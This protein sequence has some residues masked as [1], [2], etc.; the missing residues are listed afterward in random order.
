MLLFWLICVYFWDHL[1]RCS[2]YLRNW[3][4]SSS[5]FSSL[6]APEPDDAEKEYPEKVKN[7]VDAIS[8][9]TLI[10]VAEL[11]DLLKVA[12]RRS[13]RSGVNVSTTVNSL[14]TDTSLK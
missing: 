8:K 4:T 10:E 2:R 3:S 12:T 11:N 1:W 5:R 9:M 13:S 6:A 7:I 14:L